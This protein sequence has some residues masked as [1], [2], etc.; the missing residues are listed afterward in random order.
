[1]S[2]DRCRTTSLVE[3]VAG[4]RKAKAEQS[5]VDAL[6]RENDQQ[7]QVQSS[8][9][10]LLATEHALNALTASHR[11]DVSRAALYQTLLAAQDAKLKSDEG[12]LQVRKNARLTRASELAR[13]AHYHDEASRRARDAVRERKA[14]LDQRTAES[15]IESWVLRGIRE[16]SHE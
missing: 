1:M 14:L 6:T 3:R 10:R 11:V 5:L 7:Q 9:D 8:T 12:T 4:L 13:V 2:R 15:L 16:A